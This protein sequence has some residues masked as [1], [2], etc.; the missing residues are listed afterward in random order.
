[1][2]ASAIMDYLDRL[3]P[4]KLKDSWDKTG[5]Q[6]GHGDTEVKK[7][8]LSLDLDRRVLD[9]ALDNDFDMI[10]NHHPFIFKALDQVTDVDEKGSM[11]IDIIKND[12]VVY[13]AHTN[14][15]QAVGGV[16]DVLASLLG[17]SQVEILSETLSENSYALIIYERDRYLDYIKE[18]E[19]KYTR[20]SGQLRVV[21]HKLELLNLIKEFSL[22]DFEMYGLENIADS[23]GYGRVGNIEPM[24]SRDYLDLIKK[25]LDVDYLKVFGNDSL[26]RDI[27]RVAVAGGS[28]ASFIYDAYE[29]AADIYITGDIKYH[30]GQLAESLGLVLVDA[31]H[32]HTEKIILPRL[33][34]Y[35]LEEFNGLDLE[36]LLKSSPD[37][38]I[39]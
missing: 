27:K 18:K 34:D 31:G 28:G 26:S 5:F 19:L 8:L 17:L 12:L 25:Q 32:F 24:T 30:D 16:N 33:K 4:P 29:K 37:Y 6:V 7:I 23:Y 3:A 10:I 21:G 11:I 36:V 2:K 38:H 14:L 9:H 22:E 39:Y 20:S 35:I 1:M 15:D 13:N